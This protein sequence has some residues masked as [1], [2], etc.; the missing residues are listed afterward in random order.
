MKLFDLKL[1]NYIFQENFRS[2]NFKEFVESFFGYKISEDP[3]NQS[4]EKAYFVRKD[5][6]DF[7]PLLVPSSSTGLGIHEATV[8][9]DCHVTIVPRNDEINEEKNDKRFFI[10]DLENTLIK[11]IAKMEYEGVKVNTTLLKKIGDEINER[12]KF[13]ENQIWTSAG[14]NFNI[15]SSQ[16]TQKI[17]FEKLEI[18]PI[19]KIKTGFSVDN[20]TLEKLANK[21]EIASFIV[22][23]RHLKKL[24][25]TYIE[26]LLKTVNPRTGKIHTTYNQ[27]GTAT[28]RLSSENPN[29]QNIPFGDYY[30]DN[31]KSSFVTSGSD[32]ELMVADYS[33][34]E[35]RILAYL[36]QDKNLVETFAQG[37]DI[38][39]ETAKLIFNTEEITKD[40][41]KKAKTINFGVMYGI[42]GFGL[43]KMIDESPTECIKYIKRFYE[44][45]PSVRAFYDQILENARKNL[46]VETFFGRRRYI[47]TINDSNKNIQEQANREAI[48]A[49]IQGTCAD[50]IKIA[51][52]NID[53]YFHKN[54]LKS[55]LIMQ[56]HDELVFEIHK[57]EKATIAPKIQEIMEN[58]PNFPTNLKVEI[59]LGNNWKEA[60]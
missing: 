20:E 33:Q 27:I 26:G 59:G 31:I 35:L 39:A 1:K 24:Q 19:K 3:K 11:V 60:K 8:A 25:S 44:S 4:L 14:E 29:L 50:I 54:K 55:K 21:Y 56:V 38:H 48:N 2:Y 57:N 49:P 13:L 52:I 7:S 34:V 5:Y 9:Q 47:K 16:Q 53:K 45:Y 28:G 10:L 43:S 37:K 32:Y 12:T 15:N 46:Y 41:R 40:Q 36:S 18:K 58:I 6:V 30:S 22:E 51:M 17:L 42:S 23:Y